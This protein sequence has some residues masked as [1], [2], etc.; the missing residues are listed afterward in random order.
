M[1]FSI[2]YWMVMSIINKISLLF[3]YVVLFILVIDVGLINK[4]I[5]ENLYN[6]L[7]L[8]LECAELK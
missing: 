2:Y 3:G 5:P 4:I 7:Y 8:N 6:L 1:F